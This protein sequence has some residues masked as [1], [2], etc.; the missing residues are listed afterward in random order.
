MKRRRFLKLSSQTAIAIPF[1]NILNSPR[2]QIAENN[3]QFVADDAV[4][5]LFEN[6]ENIHKPFVRW[7]WNGDRVTK[8][9]VLQGSAKAAHYS[10]GPWQVNRCENRLKYWKHLGFC[11]ILNLR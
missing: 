6:P 2:P 4:Y 3:I 10:R 7:W 1:I 5:S 8:H 11:R 9:E